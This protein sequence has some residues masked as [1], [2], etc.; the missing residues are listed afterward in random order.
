[1]KFTR[2]AAMALV[3]AA[4][5][6]TAIKALPVDDATEI[7]RKQIWAKELAIYA[8]RG[9]GHLDFYI[10]NA[11]PKYLAWPP[12]A[13]APF[14]LSDLRRDGVAMQGKTQEKID[15][16]FKGFTLSGQTAVIYYT[17]HRTMKADGTQVDQYFENIHVWAREGSD[18]KVLGGMSRLTPAK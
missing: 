11:S 9:T 2:F 14:P 7:A 12:T 8:G 15:T 17:N 3:L 18:W 5:S 4:G 10:N 6:A 13:A 16:T 1:M